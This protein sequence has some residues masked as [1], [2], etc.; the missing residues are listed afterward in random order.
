MW[1]A[2]VF[3]KNHERLLAGDVASRFLAH[4]VS[5]LA[6]KCLVSKEQFSVDIAGL[7]KDTDLPQYTYKP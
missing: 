6:V 4:L 5:L 2:T 3:T 7:S 1:D